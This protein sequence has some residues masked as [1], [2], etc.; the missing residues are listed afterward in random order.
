M[1]SAADRKNINFVLVIAFLYV[2]FSMSFPK[3]YG[4]IKTVV[5]L[6]LV[7]ISLVSMLSQRKLN[8]TSKVMNWY[9][10][11]ILYFAIWITV[12][13]LKGNSDK[14]LTDS[15]RLNIVYTLCFLLL[16]SSFSNEKV[17]SIVF[18]A[19][20]VSNIIISVYTIM[21]L[22]NSLGITNF[23]F[24]SQMSTSY[25]IGVH[26]GYTKVGGDN[27]N[28]LVFTGAVTVFYHKNTTGR[29][30]T[31]S[32]ISI[33]LLFVASLF[34]GRR[35]HQILCV[36]Y[37]VVLILFGDK[38][39]RGKSFVL[40]FLCVGSLYVLFERIPDFLSF[41]TLVCRLKDSFSESSDNAKYT[42]IE[43]LLRGFAESPA[44][45]NGFGATLRGY[46]R[47]AYEPWRFEVTYVAVLFQTGM[48]GIVYYIYLLSVN[49]IRLVRLKM[50]TDAYLGALVFGYI[51]YM[52]SCFTNP[53]L[54]SFDFL[55]PQF[56]LVMY[57]NYVSLVRMRRHRI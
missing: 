4:S 17:V 45:G 8:I 49:A 28:M 32:T 14:A 35:L 27:L 54:G 30:K 41:E 7:F 16:T 11:Y 47:D 57:Y 18:D 56:I 12:G 3:V 51:I 33:V 36:V 43:A 1:D 10:L 26:D 29:G 42:Q 53:L 9:I 50:E 48:I 46:F 15:I 21:V 22:L 37:A 25:G 40:L 5:L 13:Y 2:C 31:W 24:L 23:T 52:L 6:F 44:I 20:L 34:S 19:I 55:F 39:N 38:K